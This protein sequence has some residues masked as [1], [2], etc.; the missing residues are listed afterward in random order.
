MDANEFPPPPPPEMLVEDSR[1][2]MKM[3]ES[4]LSLMTV[5]TRFPRQTAPGPPGPR[6]PDYGPQTL[7]GWLSPARITGPQSTQ[8][9][10]HC[11]VPARRGATGCSTDVPPSGPE[12][13]L[14][15]PPRSAQQGSAQ[16]RPSQVSSLQHHTPWSSAYT[17]GGSVV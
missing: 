2:S 13:D 11:P 10:R 8:Q 4:S 16:A 6:P 14:P 1:S 5:E 3:K 9:H 15:P 17:Q 7:E 12:E